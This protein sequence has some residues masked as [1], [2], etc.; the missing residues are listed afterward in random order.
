MLEL[1]RIRR[2]VSDLAAD[3]ARFRRPHSGNA[4]DDQSWD[5]ITRLL[6]RLAKP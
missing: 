2:D 5:I 6:A 4:D 3:V 1:Y